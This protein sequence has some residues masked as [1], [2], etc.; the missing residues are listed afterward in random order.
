MGKGGGVKRKGVRGD[1]GR[2]R[3]RMRICRA[4]ELVAKI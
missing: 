2:Q 1:E 3:D 4:I